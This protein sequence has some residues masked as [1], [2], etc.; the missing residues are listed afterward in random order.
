VN[1]ATVSAFN[2]YKRSRRPNVLTWI[3]FQAH[4]EAQVFGI[5][6]PTLDTPTLVA[7]AHR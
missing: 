4:A 6:E 7:R 3:D 1:K 5:A 2:S